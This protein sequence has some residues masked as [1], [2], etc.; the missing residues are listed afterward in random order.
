VP[1]TLALGARLSINRQHRDMTIAHTALRDHVFGESFN[2]CSASLQNSHFQAA[3]VIDVHVQRR[4]S[5]IVMTG[6]FAIL[7][8]CYLGESPLTEDNAFR[9]PATSIVNARIGYRYDNGWSI[10]LDILNC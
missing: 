2:F 8:W 7:R 3:I 10:H 9:S 6:P 1:L 5:Q 4:L